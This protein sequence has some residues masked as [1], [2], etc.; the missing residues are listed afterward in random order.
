MDSPFGSTRAIKRIAPT[1][2]INHDLNSKTKQPAGIRR[3]NPCRFLQ[4]PAT[5]F[6]D[7][8]RY[9]DKR[10]RLFRHIGQISF[11][12]QRFGWQ[13]NHGLWQLPGVLT[14]Q[15]RTDADFKSEL[16]Q[17]LCH[18]QAAGETVPD[19]T[20]PLTDLQFTKNVEQ[21]TG[22]LTPMQQHR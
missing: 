3:G 19:T 14:Q 21:P 18:L 8:S 10:L 15:N 12:Q 6:R 2:Q 5:Q 7:L 22:C 9:S 16:D 1:E 20:E 17:L 13:G 4:A 11:Q